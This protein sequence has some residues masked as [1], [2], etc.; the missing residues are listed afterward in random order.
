[1]NGRTTCAFRGGSARVTQYDKNACP[2]NL[3]STNGEAVRLDVS[4]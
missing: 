1:M 3:K 4:D 2:E